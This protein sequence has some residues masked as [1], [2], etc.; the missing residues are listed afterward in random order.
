M[1]EAPDCRSEVSEFDSRPEDQ[2]NMLYILK[3]L[4]QIEK[5]RPVEELL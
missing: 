3:E 5:G 2:I 1:V 4:E